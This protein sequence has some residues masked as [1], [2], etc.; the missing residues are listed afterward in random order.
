MQ[1]KKP[2]KPESGLSSNRS[3]SISRFI[4]KTYSFSSKKE[5]QSTSPP[6]T[7]EPQLQPEPEPVL[8]PNGTPPPRIYRPPLHHT[9]THEALSTH[10]TALQKALTDGW[11]R[12]HHSR[13]RDARA[14]LVCWADNDSAANPSISAETYTPPQTS[15]FQPSSPSLSSLRYSSGSET[16]ASLNR[17]S[18]RYNMR[19]APS[20]P[21]LNRVSSR[22]N[23]RNP[24]STT[25][26]QPDMRQGPFMPA[27]YQLADVLERRYGVAA[28]VWMIPSLDS[29]QDA[30]AAK[31]KQFVRDYGGPD[32]LL[33]FWYGG[34]AEFVGGVGEGAQGGESGVGEVIWY[35]L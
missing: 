3:S 15:T 14:L 7:P 8:G 19:D 23:M 20:T 10:T 1:P 24:V 13:Y 30:L 29:P 18:S 31:V 22:A 5:R 25:V 9:P 32:N 26:P 11:P 21:V 2:Q 17:V 28:Q 27:A 35:G 34:R 33:I 12:R 4:K 16:M 6:V